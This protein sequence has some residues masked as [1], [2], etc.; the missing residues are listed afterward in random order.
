MDVGEL[1]HQHEEITLTARAL[2]RAVSEER[3]PEGVA[4]LR[5]QLARQLMTH[6]ALEDRLLYPALKRSADLRTRDQAAALEQEIGAL[7]TIFNSYM[8]SWTDDRIA[9]EWP[10]FCAETREIL[11]ALTDRV[12]RE[13]RLFGT[14]ADGRA[15]GT[16]PAA[17]S[18]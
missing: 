17:R 11:R 4:R 2:A 8:A 14:L 18:A 16:P 9:R 12:G 15:A 5:W 1:R 10:A 3:Q 6:L 13:D 7:G